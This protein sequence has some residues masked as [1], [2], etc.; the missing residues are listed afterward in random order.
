MQP[1][2][3]PSIV[4]SAQPSCKPSRQPSSHP[5]TQPSGLPT[6]RPTSLPSAIPS[7]VPSALPTAVPS[8]AP[9]VEPSANPTTTPS[10]Q[11]SR[12]PSSLPTTE[13]S[14][15]PSALPSGEPTGTPTTCPSAIPSESPTT[16]PS[17][18]PSGTP[19]SKP[20]AEPSGVPSEQ[21]SSEPTSIPSSVPSGSPTVVPTGRPT[22]IP[23][24]IP[25]SEPSTFS[26][27]AYDSK[28]FE[29]CSYAGSTLHSKFWSWDEFCGF[30]DENACS[31]DSVASYTCVPNCLQ[32]C[33]NSFCETF[34]L[35]TEKCSAFS[36]QSRDLKQDCLFSSRAV[37]KSTT[38]ITFDI[39]LSY[40]GFSSE[41]LSRDKDGQQAT[42]S[43]CSDILKIGSGSVRI[44]NMA[45]ID[46]RRSLF[47]ISPAVVGI[48]TTLVT[49]RVTM[50]LEEMGFSSNFA[51]FAYDEMTT[52]MAN[53]VKSGL[54][55]AM[56]RKN[57]LAVFGTYLFEKRVDV[58][59]VSFSTFLFDSSDN[60]K[61][62]IF[63]NNMAIVISVSSGLCLFGLVAAFLFWRKGNLKRK[64]NKSTVVIVG[65][66]GEHEQ[67]D[68]QVDA[69]EM[70]VLDEIVK[71]MENEAKL[72]PEKQNKDEIGDLYTLFK[73]VPARGDLTSPIRP[74]KRGKV[75]I[76][77]SVSPIGEQPE[78]FDIQ[79]F[80][81]LRS[82]EMAV[83]RMPI[84]TSWIESKESRV[85]TSMPGYANDVVDFHASV[86]TLNSNFEPSNIRDDGN[87]SSHRK[88][89]IL[90]P[91]KYAGF[92]PSTPDRPVGSPVCDTVLFDDNAFAHTH[93]RSEID[94][95]N[96]E[97]SRFARRR[98]RESLRI[99]EQRGAGYRHDESAKHVRDFPRHHVEP[100]SHGKHKSASRSERHQGRHSSPE[101]KSRPSHR[102]GRKRKLKHKHGDKDAPG[103]GLVHTDASVSPIHT[104]AR[105]SDDDDSLVSRSSKV[106]FAP[107]ASMDK[108]RNDFS[109]TYK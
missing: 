80:S 71:N 103:S 28:C 59:G 67:V 97:R 82:T 105:R 40:Q 65:Q 43:A 32:G 19:S 60:N 85:T 37:I 56:L 64:G 52:R 77:T 63:E 45:D 58:L 62:N 99:N 74:L 36:M 8:T 88:K 20:S 29:L 102:H 61:G 18:T 100:Q 2:A 66:R 34:A 26:L 107:I 24:A 84:K 73:S 83:N 33:V 104:A 6:S 12:V 30:Y 57:G 39:F 15:L 31:G 35:F 78:D 109:F 13:P 86:E 25:T 69:S 41:E 75:Y 81:L 51:S 79:T 54:Y 42:V 44:T 94:A 50:V 14:A 72:K 106:S 4:P 38:R 11:P 17:G 9:S 46:A 101:E 76:D 27:N 21:P 5:S 3:V 23:T 90:P 93:H 108:D 53:A 16:V 92:T 22:T 55:L 98:A 49:Y 91:L 47:F 7:A 87:F 10:A 48:N 89:M 1:T 95:M 96:R 70:N 68:E